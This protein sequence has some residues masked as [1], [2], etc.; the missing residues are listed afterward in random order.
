MD[1]DSSVVRARH[2]PLRFASIEG[3]NTNQSVRIA[4]AEACSPGV[5]R[6]CTIQ[7]FRHAGRAS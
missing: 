6:W 4:R 1:P 5:R 3:K 2:V 7:D